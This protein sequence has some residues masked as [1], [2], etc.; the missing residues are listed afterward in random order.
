MS[1]EQTPNSRALDLDADTQRRI[2]EYARTAG[3]TPAEVVRKAFDEY[4]A[5]QNGA[6]PP[7]EAEETAFDVL[8][9]AG[10]IGCLK[11]PQSSPTDLATNPEHMEDFGRE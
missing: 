6:H 11:S 10:L 7:G 3:E 1:V 8:S 5:T 4:E 2:E 9:R